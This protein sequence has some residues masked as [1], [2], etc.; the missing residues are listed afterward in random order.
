MLNM[1][2]EIYLKKWHQRNWCHGTEQAAACDASTSCQSARSRLSCPASVPGK[3]ASDDPRTWAPAPLWKTGVGVTSFWLCL[4]QTWLLQSTEKRTRQWRSFSFLLLSLS[5]SLFL[6]PHPHLLFS[7]PFRPN[8]YIF[9]QK[10]KRENIIPE[11]LQIQFKNPKSK[12]Q[13]F[14][15]YLVSTSQNTF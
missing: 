3:T 8:K 15:F 6:S 9:F 5:L 2:W 14:A 10:K 12:F 7:W 4:T 1:T 13:N 11:N